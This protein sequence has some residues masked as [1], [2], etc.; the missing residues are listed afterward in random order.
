MDERRKEERKSLMA[1]TPVYDLYNGTLLGHLG[2]LSFMGLMVIGDKSVAE[3]AEITL[4]I[5]LPELPMIAAK[6]MTLLAR[7]VWVQPD[8]S[9][10][11]FSIGFEFKEVTEEQ[12]KIITA[13]IENYEFRRE[14][15]NYLFKPP[16]Q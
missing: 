16:S 2:D 4:A 5:E 15:Q 8:I 1:Y 14:P 3:N 6:R 11:Y 7:T 13:I 9:P 12:K 10:E